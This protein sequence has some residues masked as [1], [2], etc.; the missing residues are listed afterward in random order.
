MNTAA[1]IHKDI[2]SSSAARGSAELRMAGRGTQT[3]QRDACCCSDNPKTR[4]TVFSTAAH[5]GRQGGL[6]DKDVL[7]KQH[8]LQRKKKSWLVYWKKKEDRKRRRAA[9]WRQE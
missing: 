9:V 3:E 2:S 6:K 5:V 1:A 7:K 8:E 4:W